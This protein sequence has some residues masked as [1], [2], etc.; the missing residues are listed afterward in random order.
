METGNKSLTEELQSSEACQMSTLAVR[1]G[2]EWS[3]RS[4]TKRSASPGGKMGEA[5]AK[6]NRSRRHKAETMLVVLQRGVLRR[7]GEELA[8][9]HSAESESDLIGSFGQTSSAADTVVEVETTGEGSAPGPSG[10]LLH[11]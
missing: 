3:E 7:E 4:A 9:L 2:E 8:R 10:V 1:G 5:E 6:K 11:S